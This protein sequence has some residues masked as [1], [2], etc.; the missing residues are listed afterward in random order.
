MPLLIMFPPASSYT[1]VKDSG[2]EVIEHEDFC[3]KRRFFLVL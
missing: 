1:V 3:Q 2:N